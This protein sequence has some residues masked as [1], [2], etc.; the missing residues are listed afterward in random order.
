MKIKSHSKCL[1]ILYPPDFDKKKKKN[2]YNEV[3]YEQR[4][5]NSEQINY[6]RENYEHCDK[7]TK[8]K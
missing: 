2:H 3:K 1:F 7:K 6:L 4:R 5:N 8:S